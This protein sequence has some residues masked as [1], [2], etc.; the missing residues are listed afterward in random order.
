MFGREI[1][2]ILKRLATLYPIIGITGPR[3]S[4]KTT[5]A[6]LLFPDW[7]YIS[8][9]NLD[10]RLQPEQDPRA[11]LNLYKKV[12]FLTKYSMYLYF[13]LIFRRSWIII[14]RRAVI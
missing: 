11:F 3:Q 7:P 10:F 13:C 2:R 8:L 1:T 12:L 4:P 6:K 14:R 5:V 9:E